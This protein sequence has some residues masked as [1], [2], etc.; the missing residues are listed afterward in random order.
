MTKPQLNKKIL[1]IL[2][3]GRS[4][5][6]LGPSNSGKTWFIKKELM[7]FLK[8]Q[9]IKIAYFD[10]PSHLSLIKIKNADFIVVDEVETMRD[11]TFLQKAYPDEKPY[12]S[13]EYIIRV[14]KWFK[15]LERIK[16]PSIF[17]IT[18]EKK[19]INNFKKKIKTLEWGIKNFALIE[20][21]H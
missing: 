4:M 15:N 3:S 6:L 14:K 7:P 21:K 16:K 20:F 13:H 2:C 17:I 12:Y 9:K 11:R 19:D 8:K 10:N 18:R 5:V 1:S